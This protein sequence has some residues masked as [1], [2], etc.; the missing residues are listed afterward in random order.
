MYYPY[1]RAKQ[2][3]LKALREFSEEHSGSNIVPILEPVKKQSAALERAVEDMMENKMRF[4]L[5]LN[6]TDGDFKHD[7]VSFGA[8]LEES[9]QLL[10]GSQGK[11]WIPAFI[12][13]RRLLDDI[14]SLIKKYQLS[15]VMLVFKSCMDM[16]EPKVSSLVNDPRVE[17]VVNAFGAVGSRRLNT[18]LKRTGKKIIRLDDCFKTRTRNADYALEDDELFSE[19]PFYY[20][21]D[22]YDG[23]SDYTTLPSD[24]VEGGMMPYAVAIH[25]SYKKD[26][27]RLNV[28][29]FV[30]DSNESNTNVRG[31]F[32]EAA[33][34]IE[35]F[36]EG[37]EQTSS[38]KELISKAE[39][40]DGYPGLGYLK[41][42]SVKNHLELI[43]SII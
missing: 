19:E 7:T 40:P 43:A 29:H 39:D 26:E 6:P 32:H 33:C 21:N 28:H 17:F 22:G 18:I 5:V 15:N 25:L 10:N 1:L 37:K 27:D 4:A 30:S 20:M 35:P 34:K 24:Y 12:C 38:V 41:K 13:T 42:L 3:E 31:K 23:F 8:W 36:F 16:E 9:K 11:D 2:F 14:P